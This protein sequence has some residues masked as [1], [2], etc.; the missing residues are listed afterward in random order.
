MKKLIVTLG[1]LAL[2]FTILVFL[3]LPPFYTVPILVYHRI[4]YYQNSITV[5]PKRFQRQM[6]YLYKNNYKVISLDELVEGIKSRKTFA[7]KTVVI[8]F[9]DGFKDNFI[10]AFLI[11]K[12]YNFSATIFLV[13]GFIEKEKDFLNWQEIGQMQKQGILF[14]AHSKDHKYLPSISDDRDLIEEIEGSKIE[15]ESKLGT[16]IDHF[17]YITGGFNDKIK[18]IVKIAGYKS[19]CTT[20]RGQDRLNRDVFELN[21]IKMTNASDNLTLWFKLSG[22]YNLFRSSKKPN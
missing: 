22:Y 2:I 13:S 14:G 21:R 7:R 5:F 8:T 4:N 1:G 9:D 19:A 18:D 6:D 3:V 15:I 17:C 10:Y 20:N 12:E 11:L 16:K